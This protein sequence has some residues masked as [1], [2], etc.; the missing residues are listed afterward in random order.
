ME[1]YEIS[2]NFSEGESI[3][4]SKEIEK[5]E[6]IKKTVIISSGKNNY[7]I[8]FLNEINILSIV[9]KRKEGL[10]PVQ[11]KGEFILE[12]IKKVGLF[13]DYK[14]IDECLFEI[15]EGLDSK[16]TLTEKDNQNII[17]SVPLHTK[18]Y[19]NINFQL[20]QKRKSDSNKNE[21]LIDTLLNMKR[22][23][24]NEIKELKSKIE[25]LEG[26]L[27]IKNKNNLENNEK[28]EGS[29]LEIFNIGKDSYSEFFPDIYEYKENIS[30][31][32]YTLILE[33]NNEND[34]NDVSNTFYE[35][36][37]DIKK[38][39]GINDN[40]SVDIRIRKNKK[41]IYFDLVKFK[42][43]NDPLT[44]EEITNE[45]F[46]FNELIE[47]ETLV[48]YVPLMANGLKA[49]ISTEMTLLDLFEIKNQEK[50]N[51]IIYNTKLDFEGETIKSKIF[52]SFLILMFNQVKKDE[53][54]KKF[55]NLINDIFLT[56]ISG[57]YSYKLNNKEIFDNFK[58]D[59]E[60]VL[61]FLKNLSFACVNF[62][63]D[64]KF[65]VFQKLDF[66]KI[67]LGICGSPKFKVGFIG[68][69]FQSLKNNEFV[70]KV[71]NNQLKIEEEAIILKIK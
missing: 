46:L 13:H 44:G 29:S 28:I 21:D 25:K 55:Y 66:N 2:K 20:K 59:I 47:E 24:D 39:F 12:D 70:N 15:F 42:K 8:D 26:L 64:P 54:G 51:K 40:K 35:N 3:P 23:K 16:P 36:K 4:K 34:I 32:G 30:V 50:L 1:D 41:T 69:K 33:C 9:A 60:G 38:L 65:K 56:V 5:L 19:P 53:I 6:N 68:M 37:D 43:V 17:L 52:M 48:L 71:L 57:N 11:Y 45:D 63:K 67:T 7:E 10:F 27:L 61:Q 49:K 58:E 62:F 22:E 14:S 18:K 31:F